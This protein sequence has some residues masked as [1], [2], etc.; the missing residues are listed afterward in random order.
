MV[1]PLFIWKMKCAND[2][3]HGG[4]AS[5]ETS[6]DFHLAF[7]VTLINESSI[8]REREMYHAFDIAF[9]ICRNIKLLDFYISHCGNTTVWQ[10]LQGSEEADLYRKGLDSDTFSY[11]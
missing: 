6:S 11:A 10:F 1:I 4:Q 7:P 3:T 5:N 8:P 2:S 9:K